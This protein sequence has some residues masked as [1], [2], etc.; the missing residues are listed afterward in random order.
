MLL[1]LFGV[2]FWCSEMH[3]LYTPAHLMTSTMMNLVR[4]FIGLGCAIEEA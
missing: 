4:S 2:F 1:P 3:L